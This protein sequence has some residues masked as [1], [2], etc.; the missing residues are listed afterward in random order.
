MYNVI[1]SNGCMVFRG[2][3]INNIIAPLDEAEMRD[4]L[5][6]YK[7]TAFVLFEGGADIDP[8]RYGE[9]NTHSGVSPLRDKHEFQLWEIAR[10]LDLPML[11]ICRGHQLMNVAAGGTLWQDLHAQRGKRHDGR[12]EL[13]IVSDNPKFENLMERCTLNGHTFVNSYHH[14]GV[15]DLAPDA[16]AIAHHTDGLIEASV[17]PYGLSVQWH[18]EFMGHIQFVKYMF[19]EFVHA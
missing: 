10:E 16:I 6:E 3:Y 15:K 17:Y 1:C 14:Q 8:S 4:L 5:Q 7:G 12:H 19:E 18:P 11:G 9:E 2:G 13:N